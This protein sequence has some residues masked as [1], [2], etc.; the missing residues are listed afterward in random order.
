[1]AA[2]LIDNLISEISRKK[3]FKKRSIYKIAF[4]F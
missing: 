3:P 4:L 2:K 1:M